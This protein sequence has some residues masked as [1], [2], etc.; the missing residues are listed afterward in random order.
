MQAQAAPPAGRA[1]HLGCTGRLFSYLTVAFQQFAAKERSKQPQNSFASLK[2]HQGNPEEAA[3][4]QEERFI[5]KDEI[6]RI[7]GLSLSTIHRLEHE[8]TFPRRRS[9]GRHAVG[10]R[11]SE[12]ADWLDSRPVAAGEQSRD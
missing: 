5:R 2:A 7:T 8:G 11:A 9:L 6:I 12:I 3:D 4:M 10:W 1:C